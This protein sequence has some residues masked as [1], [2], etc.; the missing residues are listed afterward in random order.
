MFSWNLGLL[1]A[2]ACL[3]A[4]HAS[5]TLATLAASVKG[6]HFGL[7]VHPH[8]CA[9]VLVQVQRRSTQARRCNG[10]ATTTRSLHSRRE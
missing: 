7:V 9:C 2:S 3:V 5:A 1:L 8:V 6:L 4:V 10:V